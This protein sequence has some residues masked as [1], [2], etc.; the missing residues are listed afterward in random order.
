[1]GY[2]CFIIINKFIDVLKSLFLIF[3]LQNTFWLLLNHGK[4]RSSCWI[5][6]VKYDSLSK[7]LEVYR[8]EVKTVKKLTSSVKNNVVES[9]RENSWP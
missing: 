8:R 5:K 7:E 9:C 3:F 2:I 6:K 1:M 4:Q